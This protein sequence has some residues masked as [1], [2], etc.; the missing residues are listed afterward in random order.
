M[1]ILRKS[2]EYMD[3]HE[4]CKSSSQIS[5]I[6]LS[7][8]RVRNFLAPY[9]YTSKCNEM[10]MG[11]YLNFPPQKKIIIFLLQFPT[12]YFANEMVI[13]RFLPVSDLFG[14]RLK[15]LIVDEN[16]YDKIGGFSTE[17][18]LITTFE[19]ARSPI[20]KFTERIFST[21]A[22]CIDISYYEI[23][24]TVFT[25]KHIERLTLSYMYQQANKFPGLV[26]V[27]YLATRQKITDENFPNLIYIGTLELEV[28]HMIKIKKEI[29]IDT[30]ILKTKFPDS[31][32]S[33]VDELIKNNPVKNYIIR[34]NKS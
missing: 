23:P 10:A 4:Y 5:S 21:D 32:C 7:S 3:A 20:N 19:R 6:F 15:N 34:M 12:T 14:K 33:W 22:F 13:T 27:D 26:S 29:D 25:R 9:I 1:S 11:N 28:S 31:D 30:L 17:K 16:C 18:L 2:L 24:F 8:S